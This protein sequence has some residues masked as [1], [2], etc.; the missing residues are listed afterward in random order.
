MSNATDYTIGF[1][2]ALSVESVALRAFL[3]EE[4]AGLSHVA[5]EDHN[6]YIL[7]R[8]GQHK[9]AI[10]VLPAEVGLASAA[11]VAKDMLHTFTN[12]RFGLLVGIGGGA[13]SQ[14]QDRD[15]RLGDVAVS[16]PSNGHGGVFQYD[17]GKTIQDRKFEHTAILN[18]PPE[19][20]R[21][22]VTALRADYEFKGHS[23]QHVIEAAL[24]KNK[25]LRK[26]YS[27]PDKDTDVLYVSEFTH[28]E[29]GQECSKVCRDGMVIVRKERTDEDDDPA[30]HYGEL[31]SSR[32]L[33]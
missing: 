11:G 20:L 18:Q 33:P 28:G 13:P 5:A 16:Y 22:T 9:V 23:L 3:D 8:M 2:C 31:L 21:A 24:V 12:L 26:R 1:I 19:L 32:V 29:R 7:G 4:H 27:K 14:A 17:F 10:A 6:A 15:V 30:I 25:R